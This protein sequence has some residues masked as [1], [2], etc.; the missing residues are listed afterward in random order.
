[1]ALP[2]TTGAP[3]FL[4]LPPFDY[5]TQPGDDTW[6]VPV[7]I[8]WNILNT[9]GSGYVLLAPTT[10]QTITQPVNTYLNVNNQQIYGSTPTVRFGVAASV[11]DSA[12]TRTAAGVFSFDTN[13]VGNAAGQVD[14]AIVNAGTGFQ[15]GG[16]APNG[17][18]LIGNGSE[19]MDGVLG[20]QVIESAGTPET[21]RPA[22]NFLARFAV[23]DDSGNASTDVDLAD[24]GVTPGSYANPT[25][26]VD[27]YGRVTAA[28]GGSGVSAVQ[29]QPSRALGTVY[30]NTDPGPRMVAVD[31]FA[32]GSLSGTLSAFSDASA[33]TT[34]VLNN[35][36]IAG[37]TAGLTFL[38][39]SMFFYKVSA[40]TLTLRIWTE[41]ALT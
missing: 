40:D 1:M 36:T 19:Y 4:Y 11:W 14:A 20:Y 39:P 13:V 9:A 22:L 27:I 21:Q 38:V 33:A 34:N 6:D 24:S 16:N 3:L 26:T 32:A 10:S 12:I 29:S 41:W 30:Q 5:G 23:A 28:A 8:N 2:P 17:H 31:A 15:V 35:S 18:A 37:A 25:I 7:N